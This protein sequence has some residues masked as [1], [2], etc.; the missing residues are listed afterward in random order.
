MSTRPPLPP[1]E[2]AYTL[3]EFDRQ[4]PDADMWLKADYYRCRWLDERDRI[5]K[6]E[7]LAWGQCGTLEW[8][9]RGQTRPDDLAAL[10]EKR[11]TDL[12]WKAEANATAW[13]K[14]GRMEAW[15]QDETLGAP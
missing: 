8:P 6:D 13:A 15:N 9:A 3:E 12:Y 4:Y 14:W 1:S 11:I 7:G 2:I 10:E 5:F